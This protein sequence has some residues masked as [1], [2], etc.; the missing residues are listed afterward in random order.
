MTLSAT[1]PTSPS[2]PAP[3]TEVRNRILIVDD[4]PEMA[5]VIEQA[6]VRRGYVATPQHSA[7]GAWE[8][9]EREDWPRL[10]EV[11]DLMRIQDI[12]HALMELEDGQIPRVFAS[13]PRGRKVDVFSYLDPH[14]Q[15]PLLAH[16][17]SAEARHLLSELL[18]DDLT[19]L[20]EDL[21]PDE[22]RRLLR[23]FGD[24]AR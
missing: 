8:L 19:A 1:S 16:V 15:Y 22:V 9:L 23:L 11:L 6:L 10:R 7:D 4:E 17:S 20:L 13:L 5:A 3:S 18:P 2:S 21:P 24:V 12:A 14:Y